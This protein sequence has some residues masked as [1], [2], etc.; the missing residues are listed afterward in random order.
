MLNLKRIGLV[1]LLYFPQLPTIITLLAKKTT[2]KIKNSNR[3]LKYFY[4]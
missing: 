3:N 4:Q 1:L 2:G